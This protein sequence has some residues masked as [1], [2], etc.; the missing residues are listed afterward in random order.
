MDTINPRAILHS[1]NI[2]CYFSKRG[3]SQAVARQPMNAQQNVLRI[4]C[5]VKLYVGDK[6][7]VDFKQNS[8]VAMNK[9]HSNNLEYTAAE[10]AGFSIIEKKKN[11][12]DS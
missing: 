2:D 4:V 1:A 10:Q 11:K 7:V 3:A 8:F 6:K 5:K 9:L 12:E